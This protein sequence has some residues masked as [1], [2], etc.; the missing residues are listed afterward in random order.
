MPP[1]HPGEVLI[2]DADPSIRGLLSALVQ[3]IPRRPVTAADGKQALDLLQQRRFE[4]VILDLLVPEVSGRDVLASLATSSPDLLPK[5]VVLTTAKWTPPPELGD[6]AA[7][8]RKP[9]AI[10][11]LLAALSTC[12]EN[13]QSGDRSIGCNRPP[14]DQQVR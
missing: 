14:E 13:E 12:C 9:F 5:V 4:A 7:V 3:R 10:D 2:V 1:D 8:L 6:V 11:E